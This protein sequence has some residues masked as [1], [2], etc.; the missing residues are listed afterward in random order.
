MFQSLFNKR[1]VVFGL[2]R[3]RISKKQTSNLMCLKFHQ[4]H[5]NQVYSSVH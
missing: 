4:N 5:Y 3:S 1:F 2:E